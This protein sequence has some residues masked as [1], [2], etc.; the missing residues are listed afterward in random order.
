MTSSGCL[1]C[2]YSSSRS[3]ILFDS[4]GPDFPEVSWLNELA[5]LSYHNVSYKDS[6]ADVSWEWFARDLEMGAH[7]V[8]DFENKHVIKLFDISQAGEWQIFIVF[9]KPEI[10]VAVFLDP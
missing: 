4:L 8:L 3:W 9:L 6:L 5:S 10:W 1:L 2:A 7:T